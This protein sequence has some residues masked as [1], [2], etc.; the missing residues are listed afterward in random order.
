[1]YEWKLLNSPSF[2]LKLNYS[3]CAGSDRS[4]TLKWA[5]KLWTVIKARLVT[6]ETRRR[7]N[8]S[9]KQPQSELK[10]QPDALSSAAAV[11]SDESGGWKKVQ[12]SSGS[13]TWHLQLQ[14]S[15]TLLT[16]G[17]QRQTALLTI[18]TYT[19]THAHTRWDIPTLYLMSRVDKNSQKKP[20]GSCHTLIIYSLRQQMST[21]QK[22]AP[23]WAHFLSW[24]ELQEHFQASPRTRHWLATTNKSF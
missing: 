23:G 10:Y 11:S 6:C 13:H 16:Q 22:C 1:M 12:R 4:D 7:S 18:F 21:S 14:L 2:L 20:C 17:I 9:E 19:Q 5:W 24:N 3:C 15:L 8:K